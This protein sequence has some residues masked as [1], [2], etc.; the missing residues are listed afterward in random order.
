MS[1]HAQN[2]G[3]KQINSNKSNKFKI[4]MNV[5]EPF[6]ANIQGLPVLKRN[7]KQKEM[8]CSKQSDIINRTNTGTTRAK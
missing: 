6:L 4:Y 3:E 5:L 7:C 1:M 8:G 2:E